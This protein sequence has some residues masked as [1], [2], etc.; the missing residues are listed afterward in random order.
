MISEPPQV[1]RPH[2]PPSLPTGHSRAQAPV[3][4]IFKT[5][6]SQTQLEVGQ[7]CTSGQECPS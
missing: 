2:C 7:L 6:V 1:P 5:N 4:D 3:S